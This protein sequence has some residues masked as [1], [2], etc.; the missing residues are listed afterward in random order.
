MDAGE[1]R[2]GSRW[3]IFRIDVPTILRCQKSQAEG[4][5]PQGASAGG[6]LFRGQ[7]GGRGTCRSSPH[8]S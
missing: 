1:G 3:D 4:T 7:G 5:T 2:A 6:K 8:T